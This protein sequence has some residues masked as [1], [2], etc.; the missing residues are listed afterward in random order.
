MSTK[1]LSLFSLLGLIISALLFPV[2]P[3]FATSPSTAPTNIVVTPGP[4]TLTVTWAAPAYLNG[5]TITAYSIDTSTTGT[6]S[7]GNVSNSIPGSTYAYTINSLSPGTNYY[8]RMTAIGTGGTSPYGYPW[9]KIYS[10]STATRNGSNA[11]VYDTGYGIGGTDTSTVLANSSFSRV[12]YRLQFD[13]SGV[14]SYAEA[15]MAKWD[16][17]TIANSLAN[18][19]ETSVAAT[20]ANLRVPSV[21]TVANEFN[22]HTNVSDLTVVSSTSSL[23]VSSKQGRLEIWPWNY[24]PGLSGLTNI[25]TPSASTYDFDDSS[26]LSASYGSFQVHDI[27]DGVTILA[28]NDPGSTPDM[29]IGNN[30]GT[31]PDWTFQA[32]YTNNAAMNNFHLGIYVNIPT[33][34]NAL[35]TTTVALA[36]PTAT[37]FRTATTI[38]ANTSTSGKVTFYAFGKR[39]PGCINVVTSANVATCNWKP[40]VH[41]Q[42]PL[43]ASFVPNSGLNSNT[44]LSNPV[45]ATKRINT[46]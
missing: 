24:G 7:W 9:T 1:A 33:A 40:S 27:T 45:T 38:T 44:Q 23:N 29:G 32:N 17:T 37:S 26:Y 25:A 18:V 43:S 39:I 3:A 5:G 13:L 28:W 42:I 14:T 22:V 20:V 8:I 15:D 31:H 46:R 19:T 41:G 11:I 36:A 30:P 21:D 4:G 35:L 34:P 12:K 10:T 16:T 6:G 2:S